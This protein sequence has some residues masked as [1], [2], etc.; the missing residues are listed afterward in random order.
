MG[1]QVST[2][3]ELSRKEFA[4]LPPNSHY[5]MRCWKCGGEHEWSRRWAYYV[6][7]ARD[8]PVR[9]PAYAG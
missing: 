6:E 9:Q 2:G 4:A 7:D 1:Q 8:L 5:A 3:I